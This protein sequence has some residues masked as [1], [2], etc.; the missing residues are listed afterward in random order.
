MSSE[1]LLQ[2]LTEATEFSELPVRHN[3]DQENEHLAKQVP[4][5]VDPR[6]Y[7]RKGFD[8]LMNHLVRIFI[9]SL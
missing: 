9:G 6:H 2:V 5:Q 7:E 4:I 8:L 3:E 1:D